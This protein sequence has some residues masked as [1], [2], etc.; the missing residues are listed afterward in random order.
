[1]IRERNHARAERDFE[2]ADRIRL[3]LL[4]CG[5]TLEDTKDGT[6][7]KRTP[8]KGWLTYGAHSF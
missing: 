2:K 5:I 6:V 7:W 4:E 8:R 1:M 3:K